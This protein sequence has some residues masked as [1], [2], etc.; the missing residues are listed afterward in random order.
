M[1]MI[2]NLFF[3]A[4]VSLCV[5][6]IMAYAN[7][8]PHRG[9]LRPFAISE[10]SSGTIDAKGVILNESVLKQGLPCFTTTTSLE[11]EGRPMVVQDIHAPVSVVWNRILDF[12]SYSSMVPNTVESTVYKR[13]SLEH[14][15]NLV[16]PPRER[17][18]VRLRMGLPMLHKKI[19]FHINHLH[20]VP[21][22]IVTWT[23]DYDQA[24]DIDDTVGMWHVVPHPERP[25]EWSR[26]FYS[27]EMRMFSW[28]PKMVTNKLVKPE[29]VLTDAVTWVKAASLAKVA[30]G[31]GRS[32]EQMKEGLVKESVPSGE[33]VPM[34]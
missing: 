33:R 12:S 17:T 22:K 1:M 27:V 18:F 34:W 14:H 30:L 9:K 23:L 16:P 11:E 10:S 21:R 26:V 7:P 31:E 28:V 5:L 2:R 4:C 6:P 32:D 15:D 20:D 24:S 3:L 25:K 19:Q 8:H 29:K 13:E